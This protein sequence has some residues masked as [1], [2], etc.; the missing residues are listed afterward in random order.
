MIQ[1]INTKVDLVIDA[2]AFTGLTD[3]GEIMIGDKGFEFY[4][5]RD[6]R[7]FIQIPWE[8]VDYVIASVMF[9]GKWIPRYA[10]ETKRN[11]IFTF[12]SKEP[13]KVL[14][15]I[16]EYVDPGHMSQSLSFYDVIKRGLKS[17]GKKK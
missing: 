3:Y 15:A 10:I 11:G 8:E 7:K 6:T 14:R 16:R 13:K 5:S 4:N 1:S 2:T 9:K 12:S 17:L